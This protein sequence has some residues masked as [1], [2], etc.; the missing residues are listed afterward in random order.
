[1]RVRAHG[2]PAEPGDQRGVGDQPIDR[3]EHGRPQPS[4]GYIAVPMRPPGHERRRAGRLRRLWCLL[5]AH[6]QDPLLTK[7][8]ASLVSPAAASRFWALCVTATGGGWRERP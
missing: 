5:V 8:V 3:A 4:A 1:H 2:G 7:V 6:L